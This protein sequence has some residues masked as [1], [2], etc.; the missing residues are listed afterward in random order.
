MD[1]KLSKQKNLDSQIKRK[2]NRT[3]QELFCLSLILAKGYKVIFKKT[4]KSKKIIPFLLIEKIYN[5]NET[6]FDINQFNIEEVYSELIENRNK[7]KEKRTG[8]KVD[9]NEKYKIETKEVYT[10]LTMNSL[11][12][13]LP[14]KS[15]RIFKKSK[16]SNTVNPNFF[17]ITGIK[18][19][20]EVFRKQDIYK[21]GEMMFGVVNSVM[22]EAQDKYEYVRPI[23]NEF[24]CKFFN[25][26]EKLRYNVYKV[27]PKE[28][29]YNHKNQKDFKITLSNSHGDITIEEIIID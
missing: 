5:E 27:I 7:M 26:V 22:N 20:N 9:K 14:D 25:E 21:L 18:I 28:I 23:Q 2:A 24:L 17:H 10:S 15:I 11:V 4:R 29:V 1:E 8:K 19:G 3:A 16:Y 6:I 12:R 13:L